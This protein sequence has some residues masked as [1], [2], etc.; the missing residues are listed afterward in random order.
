M[1]RADLIRVIQQE[2]RPLVEG[3]YG[4]LRT[5]L[6]TS[7]YHRLS[8]EE[9]FRRGQAV[10]QHLA[11][12][13]ASRDETAIRRAG[14]ELGRRRFA[15]GIPLGQ[16][17]LAL[18]LEEKHL[19][20][21]GGAGPAPEESLKL[22]VAEFFG[23]TIYSTAHGFEE[24]LADS[25]RRSGRTAVPAVPVERISQKPAPAQEKSDMQISRGGDVGELGG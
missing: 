16:V 12:W 17:V 6:G 10:Y 25:I 2:A 19:W 20:V 15:E 5:N 24:A 9:L 21:Y 13:L 1:N 23:R 7:H 3:L 11:E 22:E 4:E 14:E 18:I 8:N